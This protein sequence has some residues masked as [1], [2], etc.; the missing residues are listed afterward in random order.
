MILWD[1]VKPVASCHIQ[2]YK[3]LHTYAH[4]DLSDPIYTESPQVGWVYVSMAYKHMDIAVEMYDFL[5]K[6]YGALWSDVKHSTGA[7]NLWERI[8]KKY[9]VD[10]VDF[11]KGVIIKENT[12]SARDDGWYDKRE[13]MLLA[14]YGE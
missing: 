10:L 1:M 9:Q 12:K 13:Y 14:R 4:L 5:I 8:A 2:L 11:N 7:T 6:R 3:K